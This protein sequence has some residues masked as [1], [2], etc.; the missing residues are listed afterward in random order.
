MVAPRAQVA[1][2]GLAILLG[3]RP[4]PGQ[5]PKPEPESSSR[6]RALQLR[7]FDP[8]RSELKRSLSVPKPQILALSG[9]GQWGA[10]GAGFLKGWTK[11]GDRPDSFQVVT[12]TSTGSLISTF[13][14]L[15][16]DYDDEVGRAYLEIRGDSDVM[17]KRFLLTALFKDALATTEPLRRLIERHVTDDVVAKVGVEAAK[18]RRLYVGAADVDLGIFK[19]FDLTAIASQGGSSARKDFIDALMASTAIPVAFPPVTIGGHTY[20]DGGIRR[21]VFLELVVNEMRRLRIERGL[22]TSE[23][24]VYCLVNGTLDVSEVHVKRHVLDIAKRAVDVLLDEST[25]GN[26]LRIYVQAQKA[27]MRFLTTRVPPTICQIERSGEN[28]FDP[29]LIQCLHEQAQIFALRDDAWA[30][31]PPLEESAP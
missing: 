22:T 2:L 6:M 10:F 19:P 18:G 16:R 27:Q 4:E 31:G 23:A 8:I 14:F 21:N 29:R 13:A 5:S 9:G 28:Q 25:E 17:D 24:T 15:G 26:L 7:E 3:C 11:R 30:S 1:A 12:G 20:V